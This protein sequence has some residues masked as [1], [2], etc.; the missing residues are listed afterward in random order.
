MKTI[1]K[2]LLMT[3]I[4]FLATTIQTNGIPVDP[5]SWQILGITTIG[6]VLGYLAQSF[7]F[8][9][10]S[11]LGTINVRDFIK[12]LLIA[13]ANM[14]ST[15]GAA[16]ITGTSINWQSLFTGMGAIVLAYFV[17]QLSTKAPVIMPIK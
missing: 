12:G 15:F 8:P 14:L 3:V 7:A 16:D 1:L 10:T 11:I 17:K 13:V 5:L 9:S 6:T 4:V 2:G